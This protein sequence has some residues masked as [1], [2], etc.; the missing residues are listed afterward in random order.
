MQMMTTTTQRGSSI[1]RTILRLLCLIFFLLIVDGCLYRDPY[2]KLPNGYG[3]GSISP[4]T[5]CSLEYGR[6]EQSDRNWHAGRATASDANGESVRYYW[7]SNIRS[8][9]FLRFDSKEDWRAAIN[10]Y[11]VAPSDT[12]M[13][14]V[15]MIQ[16]FNWRHFVIF[17]DCDG[18]HFIADTEHDDLRIIA[19]TSEWRAEVDRL[20]GATPGFMWSASSFW[21]RHRDPA[22]LA[23]MATLTAVCLIV[24]YRRRQIRMGQRTATATPHPS[25]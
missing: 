5:P 18:G 3:I 6:S 15:E 16:H 2:I 13:P 4:S 8:D 11:R 23:V 10:E 24:I 21:L 7:L 19:D 14:R 20:T 25:P 12:W 9:E 17:G 22:Y 1:A